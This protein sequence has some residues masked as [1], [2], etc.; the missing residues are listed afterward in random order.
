[1]SGDPYSVLGVAKSATEKEIR[2][3]FRK[4]AKKYHPDVNPG[5][6]EAEDRFKS[7][8]QAYDI[9]G[10]K[11]KRA[12][13]DRGE[14]DAE[15]QERAPFG[16]H[17]FGGEGGAQGFGGF[18]GGGGQ[19]FHGGFS[20]EDLG[21]FFDMFGAG[22]GGGSFRSGG[23]RAAKGADRRYAVT[24]PFSDAVLGTTL[25]LALGENAHTEVRVPPGVE[26]GQ[27]L[28]VRGKGAPGRPGP[29]GEPGPPGDAL[30]TIS[31]TP[32]SRY[33]RDGRNLRITQDIDLRTAVLGGKVTVPTPKGDVAVTV[34]KHSDSGKVLRLAGRGVGA[35]KTHP[36]GDLLVTLRLRLGTVT[37][38]LEAL[39]AEKE[40]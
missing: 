11:E 39:F 13:F 36:A 10:D 12:R 27:T 20:Q 25:E 3:A 35:D 1:M 5:N 28:R 34:P 26:D 30:L 24:I 4:L 9:L 8:N 33:T 29:D 19:G 31:V 7:I 17:G 21:G 40:K 37:P 32:D 6:K 15:G 38:E 16:A 2:A 22:M 14:I 18:G 23:R